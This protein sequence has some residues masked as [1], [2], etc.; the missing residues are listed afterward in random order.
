MERD[1]FKPGECAPESGVYRVV[2]HAH[3]MPHDA[4][5]ER[6]TLFPTCGRCGDRAR[7]VFLQTAP[8]VR[9]DSDFG[10][11]SKKAANGH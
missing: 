7:F 2:H 10:A 3:R 5:V 4:T 9:D 6:G 1:T 8:F 11:P